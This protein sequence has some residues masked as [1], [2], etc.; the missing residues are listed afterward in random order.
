MLSNVFL[1]PINDTLCTSGTT[2]LDA[3]LIGTLPGGATIEWFDAPFGGNSLFV[4]QN[5]TTGMISS[6]TMFYVGLCPGYSR[7]PV[8]VSFGTSIVID[9]MAMVQ[10]AENCGNAD[11]TITGVVVTGT[12]GAVTYDWNGTISMTTPDITGLTTGTY[13]LT[14]SDA[15]GCDASVGP[16]AVDTNAG[17]AIDT[18]GFAITPE[19]C[20]LTNGTITGINA[21]G[22]GTLT[23]MWNA[24]PAASLDLVGVDSGSYTLTVTDTA[25]CV[26]T[27]GPLLVPF[28]GGPIIDATNVMIGTENCN[29]ADGFVTGLV[30]TG[31]NGALVH[32]WNMVVSPGPD[33]TNA[34]AGTY[35][36]SVT[37]TAGC[38]AVSAPYDINPMAG[39]T[40]DDTNVMIS[41]PTCGLADGSITGITAM[42]GAGNLTF[43]WNATVTPTIDL[44]TAP[45]GT[46]GLTVSDTNGCTATS[47]PHI[48]A[49]NGTPMIDTSM[50]VIT[51]GNC[52]QSDGSIT[53]ITVSGGFAPYQFLW[54]GV[55]LGS[56]DLMNGAPGM[57]TLTVVD[58]NG[59]SV[60]EGTV[61]DSTKYP[62][63]FQ[64]ER[65]FRYH[66]LCRRYH[67]SNC[68]FNG[69]CWCDYF[70]LDRRNWKSSGTNRQS[71]SKFFLF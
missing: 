23:F 16:I 50:M 17:P 42:G 19:T 20:G 10:T 11:G 36:L 59:C 31:G 24:M 22:N 8:T 48:L 2:T 27:M 26:T 7:I 32:D 37:D 6:D 68:E 67:C 53:G 15:S 28:S 55:D 70:F 58:S 40:V 56:I 5:F 4:G 33:L 65:A 47:G 12:T 57:F 63:A 43:T 13:T 21:T 66:D 35:T 9:T 69:W 62:T 38:T 34:V 44:T 54:N 61:Y 18:T 49:N 29:Q 41:D 64:L 51:S 25:N 60:S 3:N 71:G 46:Y 39:P 45:A 1:D 14:V 30:V 52:Q